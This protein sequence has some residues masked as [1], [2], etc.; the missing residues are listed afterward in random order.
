MRRIES[1]IAIIA[2][3]GL[4]LATES[5]GQTGMKGRGNGAGDREAP[6]VAWTTRRPRRRSREQS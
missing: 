4:A 6:S 2:V 1:V 3:L 5:L